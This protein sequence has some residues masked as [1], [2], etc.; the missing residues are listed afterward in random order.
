MLLTASLKAGHLNFQTTQ[1]ASTAGGEPHTDLIVFRPVYAFTAALWQL[2]VQCGK[3]S[4][5]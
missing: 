2:P 4:A 1:R 5:L 3:R